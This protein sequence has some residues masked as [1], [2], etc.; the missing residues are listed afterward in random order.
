MAQSVKGK[1][2]IVTGAGSGINLSFA[3]MLLA[4]GCN[5]VIAD[6]ALRPEA[7][8]VVDAHSL[9]SESRGRAVF[10]KTDVRDW[11]QLERMFQ[12]A[13]REFGSVDIVCPGAGVYEPPFS[14]FWNPPGTPQSRDALDGNRY[15]LLDINVVHPIRT[16]QLAIARFLNDANSPSPKSLILI[17]STSAQDTSIATPLYD[18]SKHAITG[19]VRALRDIEGAARIRVAAVAPGIIKTPIYTD[20]PEKLAMIDDLN[21]V[22]VEPEEVAEVMIALIER[23][24]MSS[25]IG[26]YA[27]DRLDIPIESGLIVE[28]TKGRARP[29][30]AYHDPGP[31]G[32]GAIA[33]NMA[34]AEGAVKGLLKK[35]WGMV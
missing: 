1:T 12:T 22:W 8:E 16:S 32:P 35:G 10:Q 20:N 26:E 14:N 5:V 21:D 34:A 13:E 6:L 2:A 15:A 18:A 30:T 29:V 3:T 31:S 27:P 9:P 24:A 11:S 19:F 7:R 25:T 33:S 23:D 28:V 4:K 17:S